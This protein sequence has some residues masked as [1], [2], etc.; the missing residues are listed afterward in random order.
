M[1]ATGFATSNAAALRSADSD[2][3][4]LACMAAIEFDNMLLGR[5]HQTDAIGQLAKVI[6]ESVGD[7]AGAGLPGSLP[8]P[9][10]VAVMSKAMEGANLGDEAPRTVRDLAQQVFKVGKGLADVEAQKQ[11]RE[12]LQTMRSFCV[13]L[14]RQASAYQRSSDEFRPPHPY[15]T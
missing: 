3:P 9:T 6:S 5:G 13:M 4:S 2:L 14:S 15:R 1:N 10:T 8:N 7:T 11:H 12:W